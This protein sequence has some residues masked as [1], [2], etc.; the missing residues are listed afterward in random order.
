[1]EALLQKYVVMHMVSTAYHPQTNGQAEILNREIKLIL[2]KM[3]Q[4]NRTD[5]IRWLED[6]R[7][8][9]RTY[10]KTP[11]GMFPYRLLFGRACHFPIEIEHQN[12]EMQKHVWKENS[13]YNSLKS[14][15]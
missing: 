2:E 1:M 11:I 12:L 3:V 13:N 10:F 14:L 5:W 7:W 15:G 4:P 8:A 6:A 9:Q